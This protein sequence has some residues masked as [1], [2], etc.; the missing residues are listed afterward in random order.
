MRLNSRQSSFA[1]TLPVLANPPSL[2]YTTAD[3]GNSTLNALILPS[4]YRRP[5][6]KCECLKMANCEFFSRSQFFKTQ[7]KLR[8]RKCS[9][10]M[11]TIPVGAY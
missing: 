6:F 9:P 5:G 7:Y 3:S 8:V 1:F 2:R 11:R 4:I 10:R